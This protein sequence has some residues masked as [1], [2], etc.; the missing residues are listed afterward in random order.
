M[1]TVPSLITIRSASALSMALFGGEAADKRARG[2]A[3]KPP[4]FHL[5]DIG[6]ETPLDGADHWRARE[7]GDGAE[8]SHRPYSRAI[9][10]GGTP[11]K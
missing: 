5:P 3:M 9:A 8:R 7:D 10:L 1:V 6:R 4:G 2:L 11:R